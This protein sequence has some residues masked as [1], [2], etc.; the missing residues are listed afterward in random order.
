MTTLFTF[1]SPNGNHIVVPCPFRFPSS[2]DVAVVQQRELRQH[3]EHYKSSIRFAVL[4]A[5]RD[6]V[7][8]PFSF[9]RV[10]TMVARA[11]VVAVVVAVVVSQGHAGV[12]FWQLCNQMQFH[13]RANERIHL[14]T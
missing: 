12:C 7:G 2:V 9:A 6:T 5:K 3:I 8:S 14:T 13:K 10:V 1:P 11:L 4:A